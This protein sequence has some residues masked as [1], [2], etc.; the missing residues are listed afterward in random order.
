MRRFKNLWYY[1]GVI[2]GSIVLM[3]WM[4]SNG[5]AQSESTHSGEEHG[6]AWAHFLET[7]QHQLGHPLAILLLQIITIIAVARL[8]AYLCK[9]IGQ[10]TV[11]GEIAA[12]IILGPSF[13][14]MYFPE[15]AAFL[16]PEA[17]IG[18][19]QFLSQI[20]LIL[21]M[22]VV[23]MELD[24]GLLKN[25]ANDAI[26]ISHSAIA[27][28]FTLG[29]TLAFFIYE[30]FAP[31]NVPFLSFALF[32][33]I[34]MS[35][36]AFPI[37]ARIIQE[38]KLSGTQIGAIILTCAATD[39]VT[40]W[41]LLAAV[42]AIVKAG[43]AV[44]ALYTLLLTSIYMLFML[45]LVR[46]FLKRIGDLYANREGLSR[47][48]VAVF[49]LTLLLSAF[50]T[51][52]I[53]IHALFGA[54]M[55]GLIMPANVHFRNL[56]IEKVE[57]VSLVLLLPLFFVY[58]GIRTQIGLL[59][60]PALWKICALI[61]TVAVAGKFLGAGIS[62]RFVGQSW[63]NS[64]IIG[65]LM[66][67]RGLMELVVL[68]IG[69]DLGVLSPEMFAMMVLMALSTTF[70]TGPVLD[71]INR[72]FPER[73]LPL[74]PEII[75]ERKKY[76]ILISFGN[77]HS[78]PTMLK[79]AN[80]LIGRSIQHADITAL[81]L[82]L[83][84]ELT[85]LNTEEY[86]RDSFQPIRTEA[87][88]L[89][90]PIKTLFIPTQDVDKEIINAANSGN[91]D[92]TIIGMGQSIFEGTLL[93]EV[94]GF[95]SK[96][97]NPARLYD[98]L[99]GKEKLFEQSPFDERVR[100]ITQ[101]SKTPIGIFINKNLKDIRQVLAPISSISDSMLLFYVQKLLHNS[102]AHITMIDLNET[103]TQNTEIQ[104]AIQHIQLNNPGRLAIKGGEM[105]QTE[106]LAEQDLMLV[107]LESWKK[108]VLDEYPWLAKT[109]STLLI[110]P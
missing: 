103:I 63:R 79:V 39:D 76:N 41:C 21:F 26:V 57:D 35:I 104:S 45:L 29:T 49:F 85:P 108:I 69:Y 31:E 44:S 89:H 82:S 12:G 68:N 87:D 62:A 8:F 56:F 23:G 81:H 14:G 84:N 13:L 46:P 106:W 28:S 7:L 95:T 18:N 64:L 83:G 51:E 17:S 67:T 97:I 48:I 94:L 38:K 72:F 19:L 66:N 53:G 107:S 52:V 32:T 54:F 36:T 99:T 25:L 77:P 40:A 102:T 58:T 86:E 3:Y 15:Y 88:K 5:G 11:I 109:P 2:L 30:D 50:A 1:L 20:G 70:M 6:S 60:D 96:I 22:F 37:L 43:S 92:L 33:G 71:L 42:I 80:G 61:I 9:K 27:I 47:P 55:A 98:T 24:I 59:N 34:A 105:L 73:S 78:G 91:Y 65:A 74:T 90:L 10:P 4:V 110:K 100:Q 75:E 101:S 16:F 93:G